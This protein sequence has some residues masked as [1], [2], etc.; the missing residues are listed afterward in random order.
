M[1]NRTFRGGTSDKWGLNANWLEGVIPTNADD[2]IFDASSPDCI[3][4]TNT[5]VAKTLNF[6]GFT[7]DISR[8]GIVNRQIT[9]SGD[10]TLSSTMSETTPFILIQNETA[11]FTSNGYELQSEWRP[12]GTKTYTLTENATINKFTAYGSAST[13][14]ING[15]KLYVKKDAGSSGVTQITGTTVLEFIGNSVRTQNL[16]FYAQTNIPLVLNSGGYTIKIAVHTHLIVYTT[17]TYTSGVIDSSG[18]AIIKCYDNAVLDT[19]GCTFTWLQYIGNTNNNSTTKATTIDFSALATTPKSILG[20]HAFE[21]ADLNLGGGY[22]RTVN[23]KVGLTYKVTNSIY[24]TAVPPG[25]TP[26]RTF[27]S[28]TASSPV[29]IEFTGLVQ[30]VNFTRWV[31]VEFTD[32][33]IYNYLGSTLR[34]AKIVDMTRISDLVQYVVPT[35]ANTKTGIKFGIAEEFTG[36]LA[37]GGGAMAIMT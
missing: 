33:T 24:Q 35:E 31:D 9:V 32:H 30:G 17:L 2:V 13:V 7:N 36:T 10:I 18:G 4:N 19:S 12:S 14:T 37:T 5:G 29:Y 3:L 8:D 15:F 26:H 11:N 21:C 16:S 23:L 1:A 34:T 27:Q 6:T 28:S 22:A 25:T 20:T